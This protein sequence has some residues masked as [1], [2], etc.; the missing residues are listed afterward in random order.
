V[1]HDPGELAGELGDG[2]DVR[3]AGAG[4]GESGSV[5]V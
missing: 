1:A 5:V 2:G 3:A 4:V